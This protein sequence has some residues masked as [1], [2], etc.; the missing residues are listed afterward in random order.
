LSLGDSVFP[1]AV[2]RILYSFVVL[3][4]FPLQVGFF[5]VRFL[6]YRSVV[7]STKLTL[8]HSCQMFPVH[9][10]L[11]R[12]FSRASVNDA[13][14]PATAPEEEEGGVSSNGL[15]HPHAVANLR[16]HRYDGSNATTGSAHFTALA[17]GGGPGDRGSD[18]DRSPMIPTSS[19]NGGMSDHEQHVV[20]VATMTPSCA[21]APA[22][23]LETRRDPWMKAR[24]IVTVF[25]VNAILL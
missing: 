24:R 25:A 13:W 19:A 1:S 3:A 14:S 21:Q 20:E 4:S 6:C 8:L 12:I 2:V 16:D 5:I 17:A 11:D 18:S 10:E 22:F 9:D 15:S 23:P 7:A